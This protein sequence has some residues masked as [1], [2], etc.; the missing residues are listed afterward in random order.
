V[1][2]LGI[3]YGLSKIGLAISEGELAQPLMVIQNSEKTIGEIS[4]ICREYQ[5]E[6]LVI[7][8][9]EDNL[10]ERVKEF[11]GQLLLSTK[12]IFE[13]QDETLTTR[14]ALAKMIE[15]KKKKKIRE[16]QKD[17]FAAACILEEYLEE[18]RRDV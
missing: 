6:R 1:K 15:A 3:D 11:A 16:K 9:P 7:G 10:G 5:I 12:I 14:Q 2:I 4:K 17:A 18:R 8:L 13:F